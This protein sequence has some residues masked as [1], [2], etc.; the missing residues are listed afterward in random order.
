[1]MRQWFDF[2]ALGAFVSC[3]FYSGQFTYF[4]EGLFTQIALEIDQILSVLISD[5][6]YVMDSFVKIKDA[7]FA[8]QATS[9]VKGNCEYSQRS[10]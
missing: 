6:S 8:R 9:P 1:M 3:V 5:T 2:G 10:R 7:I 4:W